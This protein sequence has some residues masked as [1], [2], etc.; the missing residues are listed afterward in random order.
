MLKPDDDK[1]R[2]VTVLSKGTVIRNEDTVLTL[3]EHLY[4]VITEQI[5]L[6]NWN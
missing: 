3:D 4:T 5:D 1:T 6:A 2:P